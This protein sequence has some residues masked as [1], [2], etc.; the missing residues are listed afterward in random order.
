MKLH[1]TFWHRLKILS[2]FCPQEHFFD[3]DS[4]EG[5]IAWRIKNT[6]KLN[7]HGPRHKRL[8]KTTGRSGPQ[9]ERT[10]AVAEERQLDGDQVREA[11]SLLTHSTDEDQ[12]F[13]KMR[14]TFQH[15]QE[16]IHDPEK[17]S[18]VLTVFRRFL[19]TKG[20]VNTDLQ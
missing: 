17:S 8:S 15:R 18:T 6:Q 3:A 13:Q 5:Y 19:D 9:L 1:C 20:L 12:I 14:E 10:V 11:I 7:S 2:L 4:N 16:M